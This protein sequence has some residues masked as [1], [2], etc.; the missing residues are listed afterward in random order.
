MQSMLLHG[1]VAKVGQF[2]A[3]EWWSRNHWSGV[4]SHLLYS[5]TSIRALHFCVNYKEAFSFLLRV[6]HLG[7]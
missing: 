4:E 6:N 3:G 5:G 2:L 7:G 1:F